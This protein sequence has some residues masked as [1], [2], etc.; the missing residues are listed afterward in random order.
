LWV[1]IASLVPGERWL[2]D[3]SVNDE[4]GCAARRCRAMAGELVQGHAHAWPLWFQTAAPPARRLPFR[5]FAFGVPPS[6]RHEYRFSP[7]QQR[8][9]TACGRSQMRTRHARRD[10]PRSLVVVSL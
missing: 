5:R 9:C 1:C 2:A 7:Q 4:G 3:E 6:W 8:R 10:Q